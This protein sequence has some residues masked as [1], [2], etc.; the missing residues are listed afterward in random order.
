M[1]K[2][3]FLEWLRTFEKKVKEPG[4]IRITQGISAVQ[5]LETEEGKEFNRWRATQDP[6]LLAGED[7]S[8]LF[9]RH[10]GNSQ[11]PSREPCLLE[12]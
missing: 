9:I 6:R 11:N 4:Q 7:A 12:M 1:K 5:A 2:H 3:V 8:I 10:L